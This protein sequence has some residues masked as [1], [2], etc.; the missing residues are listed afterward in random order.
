[1]GLPGV[2]AGFAYCPLSE[3]FGGLMETVRFARA[4]RLPILARYFAMF[5]WA[6]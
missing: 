3:K 2:G 6:W 4:D 5:R 1:M